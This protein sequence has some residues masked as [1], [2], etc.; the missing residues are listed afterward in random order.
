MPQIATRRIPSAAPSSSSGLA[1]DEAA[2]RLRLEDYNELTRSR[3]RG[4]LRI[5]ADVCSEPMFELLAAASAIYFV[6]GKLGEA[7]ILAG[8]ALTTSQIL[9]I[10]LATNYFWVHPSIF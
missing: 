8:S 3:K 6:L 4:L 2:L 5:A 10:R 7:L 9:S 1:E